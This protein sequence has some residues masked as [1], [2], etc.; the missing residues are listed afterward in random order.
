M[1]EK[2]KL[3]R[4]AGRQKRKKPFL[5]LY[6]FFVCLLFFSTK[7]SRQRE[8]FT[9]EKDRVTE[10]ERGDQQRA[11]RAKARE[12]ERGES[13]KNEFSSFFFE[14]F[15]FC[16]V[17]K[18]SQKKEIEKTKGVPFLLLSFYLFLFLR[19]PRCRSRPARA[20]AAA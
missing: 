5:N 11:A 1:G 18:L 7:K 20:S 6:S 2:E 19:W 12:R 4:D 10:S 15:F 16:E 17:L 9:I 13:E 8:K 14:F 3:A